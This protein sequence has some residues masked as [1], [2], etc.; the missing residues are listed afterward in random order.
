MQEYRFNWLCP[1]CNHHATIQGQDYKQAWLRLQENKNSEEDFIIKLLS[2]L[3]PNPGC[4]QVTVRA[5]LWEVGLDDS[6]ATSWSLIPP[7]EAKTFPEYVPQAIREDYQ[8]ACL[9]R[10]I[11]PKASATLSRRCLQGMIRD[12]W[13]VSRPNLKQEI[14][15]IKD[16]VHSDEWNAIDAVRSIGNIGAHMEKDINAIIEVDPNEAQLLVE[17]IEQLIDD[18]YVVRHEREGRLKKLK[19]LA[20]D[21][22]AARGNRKKNDRIQ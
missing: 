10:D 16:K 20:A 19:D 3:C 6:P 11:S 15:A 12:Y 4:S 1:F 7:S 5:E 8:E 2:I 14:D 18:W 13:G 21:K 17:L 9:I 22:N